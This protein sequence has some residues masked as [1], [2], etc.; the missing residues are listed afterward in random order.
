MKTQIE[1]LTLI[2]FL[3]KGSYGEVYLTTKKGRKG[4]FATKK[5]ER[6]IMDEPS[7]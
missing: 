1:D 2:K 5:M 7:V 3:G 6:K 4:Y